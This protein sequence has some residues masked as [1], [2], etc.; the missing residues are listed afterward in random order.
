MPD[1]GESG[2]AGPRAASTVSL[3]KLATQKLLLILGDAKR[4]SELLQEINGVLGW[5][6]LRRELGYLH[7]LIGHMPLLVG[8]LPADV[9]QKF[10]FVAHPTSI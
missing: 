4:F 9:L 1:N 6:T 3:P 8:D 10:A 5:P 2:P 7:L